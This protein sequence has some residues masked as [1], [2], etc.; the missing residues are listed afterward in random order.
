LDFSHLENDRRLRPKIYQQNITILKKYPPKCNHIATIKPKTHI[1]QYGD[2]R[3]DDHHLDKL[4]ELDYLT[5]YPAE[6]FSN[7]IAIELANSLLEQ[8]KVKK[9]L[10]KT[11]KIVKQ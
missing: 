1:N 8:L 11:L 5:N 10:I 9:Y 4:S 7:Y 3:Y 2:Q 6:F